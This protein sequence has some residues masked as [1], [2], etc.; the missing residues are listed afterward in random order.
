MKD[1][2]KLNNP[3]KDWQILSAISLMVFSHS[4]CSLYHHS[5]YTLVQYVPPPLCVNTPGRHGLGSPSMQSAGSKLENVM[6]AGQE[7]C[8]VCLQ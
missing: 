2:E 7:I 5:A 4:D 6:I 8:V 3:M 1:K